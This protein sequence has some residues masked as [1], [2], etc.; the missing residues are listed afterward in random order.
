MAKGRKT[1]SNSDNQ[2]PIEQYQ[3][4]DKDCLNNPPVGLVSA[5]TDSDYG[6]KKTK[7]E[8]DPHLDPQ[9]GTRRLQA[10]RK[11]SCQS[12]GPFARRQRQGAFGPHA[13]RPPL[14]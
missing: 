8:Y 10:G 14:P 4:T 13:N 1:T 6:Q 11:T 12:M 9:C 5:M 3:H 7:Y 2:K